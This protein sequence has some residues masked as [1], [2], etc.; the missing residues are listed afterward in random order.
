ML[1]LVYLPNRFR[2]Q[3]SLQPTRAGLRRPGADEQNLYVLLKDRNP[4]RRFPSS[5][6]SRGRSGGADRDRTGDP[7]LAKQVLSQ[8]SYSPVLRMVGLGRFE[9]PT[10]P[11]SGVRSNQL[12]YRPEFRTVAGPGFYSCFRSFFPKCGKGFEDQ[13]NMLDGY[14]IHDHHAF[15]ERQRRF[16]SDSLCGRSGTST[17][18]V[19]GNIPLT[20]KD[21]ESI[22]AAHL[23]PALRGASDE[24][25]DVLS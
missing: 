23:M 13:V 1:S 22:A 24:C 12:S 25:H 14:A 11:L 20:H 21:A 16:D 7:L 17:K 9:L 5:S 2:C 8:L 10:S 19:H 15:R 3:T 18:G 4:S 6:S